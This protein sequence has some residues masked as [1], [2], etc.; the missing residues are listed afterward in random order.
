MNINNTYFQ[1]QL[2]LLPSPLQ[3]NDVHNMVTQRQDVAL[4][5]HDLQA[6]IIPP[7]ADLV[8]VGS[9][10]DPFEALDAPLEL[11]GE[12]KRREGVF[13]VEAGPVGCWGLEGLL[14]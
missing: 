1:S 7:V 3:L 8:R 9:D 14:S 5:I 2:R 11:D 6:D 10:H 12:A 13:S 4:L